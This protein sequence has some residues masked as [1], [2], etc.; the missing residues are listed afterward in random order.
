L[1]LITLRWILWAARGGVG[2]FLV[3]RRRGG[4]FALFFGATAMEK[5]LQPNFKQK[6]NEFTTQIANA[7]CLPNRTQIGPK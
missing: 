2:A 5:E 4:S 7:A 6:N 3:S 1:G